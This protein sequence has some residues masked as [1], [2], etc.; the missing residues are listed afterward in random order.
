MRRRDH[1]ASRGAF[2]DDEPLVSFVGFDESLLSRFFLR[3]ASLPPPTFSILET[4]PPCTP[5]MHSCCVRASCSC[6]RL[7]SRETCRCSADAG[8]SGRS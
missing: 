6:S 2:D 3:Q 1:A 8:S 5:R 7:S 4:S